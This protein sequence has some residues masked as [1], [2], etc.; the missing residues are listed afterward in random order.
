MLDEQYDHIEQLA[1]ALGG[2]IE[3]DTT[4]DVVALWRREL[5]QAALRFLDQLRLS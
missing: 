3:D 2:Q 5:S 4:V 1:T